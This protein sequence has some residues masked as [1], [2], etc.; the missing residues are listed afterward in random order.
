MNTGWITKLI[1]II[2]IAVGL[3][4]LYVGITLKENLETVI[5]VCFLIAGI[6][7]LRRKK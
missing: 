6:G 4:D 7:Y 5:G 3:L 2:L 1:G